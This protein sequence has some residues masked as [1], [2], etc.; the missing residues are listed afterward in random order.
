MKDE[1]KEKA[2]A[3]SFAVVVAFAFAVPDS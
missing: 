3:Q 2:S 1:G